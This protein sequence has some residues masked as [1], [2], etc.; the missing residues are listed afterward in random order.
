MKKT[1]VILFCAFCSVV[2][3]AGYANADVV[4][5]PQWSEFCPEKYLDA[6]ESTGF[7]DAKKLGPDNDY[8]F[9]RKKQFR[10]AVDLCQTKYKDDEL[11]ECYTKLKEEEKKK[12]EKCEKE[13]EE[14][15]LE[16]E[17]R[18]QQYLDQQRRRDAAD[19]M[20]RMMRY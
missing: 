6:R 3:F 10:E 14:K 7:W 16:M 9:E 4:L 15:K 12:N 17:R 11:N 13:Q 18:Q 1:F 20:N 5:V 19:Y 8:W 2:L